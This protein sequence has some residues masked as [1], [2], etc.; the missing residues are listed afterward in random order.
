MTLEVGPNQITDWETGNAHPSPDN[1]QALLVHFTKWT[2][3]LGWPGLDILTAA[4]ES[5][6]RAEVPQPAA[7]GK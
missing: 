4:A 1:L 3:Q 2:R 6:E 7:E 5:E